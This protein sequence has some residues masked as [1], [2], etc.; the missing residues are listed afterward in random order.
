MI[1]HSYEA[2][3]YHIALRD[4]AKHWYTA[5]NSSHTSHSYIVYALAPVRAESLERNSSLVAFP[6]S[7]DRG[8]RSAN[9]CRFK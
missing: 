1:S 8:G 7:S 4:L 9:V 5:L 6:G 3:K 2:L